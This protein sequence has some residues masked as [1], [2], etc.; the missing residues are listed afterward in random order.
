MRALTEQ[1]FQ[2]LRRDKDPRHHVVCHIK[3]PVVPRC[4]L[5]RVGHK[6]VGT[7]N[8]ADPM[9]QTAQEIHLEAPL[10]RFRAT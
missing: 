6:I 3:V 7:A 1:K 9:A 2:A 5:P 8:A 10:Y 4:C